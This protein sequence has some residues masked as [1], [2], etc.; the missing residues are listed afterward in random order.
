MKELLLTIYDRQ[1]LK[2]IF[3]E[4][5]REYDQQLQFRNIEAITYSFNQA[6]KKIRVSHTTITRLVREGQIAVT[7]DGRRITARALNDYLGLK[8]TRKP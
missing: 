2:D 4:V 6:A 3:S 5:L 8:E 7:T 1:E